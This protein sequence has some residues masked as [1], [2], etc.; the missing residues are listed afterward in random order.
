MLK[1]FDRTG[2]SL[3]DT[4]I[5]NNKKLYR[6]ELNNY[7]TYFLDKIVNVYEIRFEQDIL[8]NLFGEKTTASE[9]RAIIKDEQS[10]ID[11][12]DDN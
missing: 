4:Y 11:R 9:K 2:N 7:R 12:P 1:K 8:E 3:F 6:K 10:E 5:K